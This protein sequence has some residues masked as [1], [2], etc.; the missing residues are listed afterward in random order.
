MAIY[1]ASYETQQLTERLKRLVAEE[2]YEVIPY[3]EL[4][5]LIDRDVQHDDAA[6][7]YLMSA[8]RACERETNRL[9]DVVPG[10]GVKLLTPREQALL[11]P[12][13]IARL[14]RF[15]RR[16]IGRM[17]KAQFDK[18]NND[19]KL[20][21]NLSAS[22]LGA[23]SLFGRSKSIETVR[24]AVKACADKL[25]IGETLKLFAPQS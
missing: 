15:T 22:I 2:N 20:Q 14:R 1:Q 18:M 6:R 9:V 16:R 11:G 5:E 4:S 12:D 10:E 24:Q 19:E 3:S 8:R 21:H 7:G 23:V 17:A 13:A 25:P